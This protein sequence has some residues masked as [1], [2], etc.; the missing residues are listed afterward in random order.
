MVLR[1]DFFIDNN[2]RDQLEGAFVGSASNSFKGFSVYKDS[3]YVFVRN[4]RLKSFHRV[5]IQLRLYD[6]RNLDLLLRKRVSIYIR[7]LVSV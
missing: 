5:L 1:F 3:S 4:R 6:I 2:P 7:I